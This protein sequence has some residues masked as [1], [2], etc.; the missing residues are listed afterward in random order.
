[1]WNVLSL[2]QLL[3][4]VYDFFRLLTSSRLCIG[5]SEIPKHSLVSRVVLKILLGE[6]DRFSVHSFGNVD[7]A[8]VPADQRVT[9]LQVIN[10]LCLLQGPVILSRHHIRPR[11][12][13]SHI[14]IKWLSVQPTFDFGDGFIELT[15]RS[16]IELSVTKVRR[17]TVR[18][19]FD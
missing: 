12:R 19:Q 3:E 5:D 9:R 2:R 15:S 17:G 13:G 6:F 4:S 8:Q 14:D 11:K 7:V 1:M 10:F 18:V 16:E